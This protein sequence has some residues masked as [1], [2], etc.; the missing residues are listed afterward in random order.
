MYPGHNSTSENRVNIVFNGVNYT[1]EGSF[2]EVAKKAL[3]L[4]MDDQFKGIFAIKP[5][6]E[7]DQN[8]FNFWVLISEDR[9]F[10]SDQFEDL[11]QDELDRLSREFTNLYNQCALKDKYTINLSNFDFEATVDIGQTPHSGLGKYGQAF[12]IFQEGNLSKEKFFKNALIHELGHLIGELGD[13]YIYGFQGGTSYFQNWPSYPQPAPNF[14]INPQGYEKNGKTTTEECVQNTQW[15]SQFGQG[16]GNNGEIDCIEYSTS[17]TNVPDGTIIHFYYKLP[18]L[19]SVK[20]LLLDETTYVDCNPIS[21]NEYKCSYNSVID[22]F[23][24]IIINGE[25]LQ[26][27]G[28]LVYRTQDRPYGTTD[29]LFCTN[30]NCVNE[31]FCFVGAEYGVDVYRPTAF[32]AMQSHWVKALDPIF[33]PVNEQII[34]TKLSEN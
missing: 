21:S 34:R 8:N 25:K 9:N 14:Y 12:S 30:P 11:N 15:K 5:F 20:I 19:S 31:V 7:M 4:N 16:C 1:S 17:M 33:N 18:I 22:E 10:S 6:S 3:D 32:S 26:A 28:K 13:E 23:P 29:D 24:Y 27:N 2:K